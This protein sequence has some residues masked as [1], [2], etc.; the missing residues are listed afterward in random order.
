MEKLGGDVWFC[1]ENQCIRKMTGHFGITPYRGTVLEAQIPIRSI[2]FRTGMPCV[3][4]SGD[5]KR[6]MQGRPAVQDTRLQEYF[7][8]AD[9]Y[10]NVSIHDNRPLLTVAGDGVVVTALKKAEAGEDMIL[11]TVNLSSAAVQA[12]VTVPGNICVAQMDESI[13]DKDAL[14]T[15]TGAKEIRTYR[16]TP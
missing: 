15:K 13:S 14:E 12:T 7:F 5:E 11:R 9:P 2:Q 8:Y 10:A 4:T 6:F 16:I 1:P 3:Y